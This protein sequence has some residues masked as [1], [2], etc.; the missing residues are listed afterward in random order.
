MPAPFFFDGQSVEDRVFKQGDNV[1]AGLYFKDGIDSNNFGG[2]GT[3]RTDFDTNLSIDSTF[4]KVT[5]KGGDL[6][7]GNYA[8]PNK[9]PL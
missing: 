8:N 5:V 2:V 4:N 3:S 6:I 1:V 7:L 9:T